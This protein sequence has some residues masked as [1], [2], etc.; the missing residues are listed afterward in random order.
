MNMGDRGWTAA[1][2][3]FKQGL[4]C[5]FPKMPNA[6][7]PWEG[8]IKTEAD[9]IENLWKVHIYRVLGVGEQGVKVRPF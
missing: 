9:E 6:C 5:E 7:K 4:Q 3:V 2:N 1:S 8:G